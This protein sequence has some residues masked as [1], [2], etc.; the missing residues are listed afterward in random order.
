M[1]N[2]DYSSIFNI[3]FVFIFYYGFSY[4][5]YLVAYNILG[6]SFWLSII[7]AVCGSLLMSV[8]FFICTKNKAINK[9]IYSEYTLISLALCFIPI[10]LNQYQLF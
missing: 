1:K 4:A 6:V 7:L 10:I 8:L 3:V 9:Y 5:N 2:N